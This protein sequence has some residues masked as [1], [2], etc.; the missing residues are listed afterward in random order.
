[1]NYT[2]IALALIA[3]VVAA[4]ALRALWRAFIRATDDAIEKSMTDLRRR[5]MLNDKRRP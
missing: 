2:L 3:V 5:G 4:F 1:M